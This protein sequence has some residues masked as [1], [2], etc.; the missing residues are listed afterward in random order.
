ML[1]SLCSFFWHFIPTVFSAGDLSTVMCSSPDEHS[2]VYF[3][4]VHA[5]I[6]FIETC[7]VVFTGPSFW[8]CWNGVLAGATPRGRSWTCVQLQIVYL[9]GG[10]RKYW[11]GSRCW[12]AGASHTDLVELIVPISSQ[13]PV[14]WGHI[15]S[16]KL[17]IIGIFTPR[18]VANGYKPGRFPPESLLLN[19]SQHVIGSEKLRQ[20]RTAA[21]KLCFIRRVTL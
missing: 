18:E 20:G 13:I 11:Y 1:F 8:E 19:I 17:A 2:V 12:W 7:Y 16:L 6:L 5:F 15:G 21:N 9:G 4:L 10:S 14:Q 3:F